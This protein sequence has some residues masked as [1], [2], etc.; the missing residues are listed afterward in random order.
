MTYAHMDSSNFSPSERLVLA[1]TDDDVAAFKQ[2]NFSVE[3]LVSMRFD[4]MMNILNFAVDQERVNIVDHLAK[5]TQ[6]RDD[7]KKELV[8]YKFG[9]NQ[10]S[11]IHQAMIL[12]NRELI[13]ILIDEF[14]APL[15]VKAHNEMNVMHFAAQQYNGYISILI[16]VKKHGFSV[17]CKDKI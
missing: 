5:L 2:Q 11:A 13:D 14:N 6:G 12:G 15:D 4:K 17:N 9:Q 16:L 10:N 7:L 3:E 8:D 1:I